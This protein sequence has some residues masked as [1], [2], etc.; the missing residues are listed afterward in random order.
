MTALKRTDSSPADVLAC[1]LR[2]SVLIFALFPKTRW[3][4]PYRHRPLLSN[5]FWQLRR[6]EGQKLQ[7]LVL[8]HAR[9]LL[10]LS[11]VSGIPPHASEPKERTEQKSLTK[12]QYATAVHYLL[13]RLEIC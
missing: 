6:S 11:V 10:K 7:H 4:L 8:H 2:S 5:S 1:D 13:R 3:K 9:V 12:E